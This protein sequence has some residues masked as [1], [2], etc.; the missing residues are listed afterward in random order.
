MN[1]PL[2]LTPGG[3]NVFVLYGALHLVAVMVCALLIAAPAVLGRAAGKHA[4]AALRRTLAALALAYWFAYAIWWNWHGVDWRGGLPLQLCDLNGLMAPVA[5]LTG[6]RW[7]RAALYFWTAALT[8]QVFIQP[9]LTAGPAALTFWAFW[10]SHTLIAACAVYDVAVSD[11]RPAWRD[12]G[13]ALALSAAYGA[14][15]LPFDLLLGADYGF[16]GNPAPDLAVPPFVLML[17]PWPQRAVI[18]AALVPLGFV[19][20]L[21]PWRIA[22]RRFVCAQPGTHDG[23]PRQS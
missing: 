22:A 12:L 15:I 20:V 16:I 2:D 21:L 18:L 19:A 3:W 10:C 4:A 13:R 1:P 7:A 6:R 17:G 14:L 5:L 23:K 9:A 11:F 8:L